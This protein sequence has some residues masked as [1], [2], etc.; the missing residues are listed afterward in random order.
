MNYPQDGPKEMKALFDSLGLS[1][2]YLYD[3]TQNMAKVLQAQCT[4]EFYLYNGQGLLV[5]RGR[6][7]DSSPGNDIKVSGKDL[8]DAINALLMVNLL[9]NFSNLLWGAV[10][11]GN[12][13]ND[14]PS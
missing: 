10:S 14:P 1:F 11:N 6:L 7:D 3:E 12:D 13:S 9:M 2:P 5:Y 8:R 4:P